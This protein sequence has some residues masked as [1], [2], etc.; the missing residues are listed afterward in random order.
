MEKEQEIVYRRY[1]DS[2]EKHLRLHL[3]REPSKEEVNTECE[4]LVT[5]YVKIKKGLID[6]KLKRL[7]AKMQGPF[8]KSKKNTKIKGKVSPGPDMWRAVQTRPLMF[9]KNDCLCYEP[10]GYWI[11][12][13][14]MKIYCGERPR[15]RS[16]EGVCNTNCP[17]TT[18][19][20][21]FFYT[22]LLSL[23]DTQT[24]T[25]YSFYTLME[26]LG[27]PSP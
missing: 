18:E 12:P 11:N 14:G 25:G 21:K 5:I 22:T 6:G 24:S 1:H 2:L 4:E 13:K 3:N 20:L 10:G 17:F 9:G 26:G 15:L 23:R 19:F 16:K 8:I 7:L 27:E